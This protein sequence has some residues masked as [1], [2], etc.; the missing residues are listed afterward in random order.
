MLPIWPVK[1]NQH[2]AIPTR[3][4]QALSIATQTVN[5]FGFAGHLVYVAATELCHR[6]IVC[7]S[8]V[9][10]RKCKWWAWP[11]SSGTI[12]KHWNFHFCVSKNT[13]LGFSSFFFTTFKKK[14]PLGSRLY[15]DKRA[16]FAPQAVPRWLGT[17]SVAQS[18][19]T[20][21]AH[22]LQRSRPL[23]PFLCV[24][25]FYYCAFLFLLLL[26]KFHLRA[27][28]IRP[29][30]RAPL[31]ADCGPSQHLTATSWVTLN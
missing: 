1:L 12:Y 7:V 9:R 14:P 8:T 24:L 27:L 17:C 18:C 25:Y 3:D 31:L 11:R 30:G 21:W 10:D 29:R 2:P 5:I 19:P 20:L 23:C 6:A 22:G 15:R 16:R 28:G 26:H 13:T 4:Q